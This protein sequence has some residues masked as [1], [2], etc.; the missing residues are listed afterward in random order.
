MLLYLTHSLRSLD[1]IG[2][3]QVRD[4]PAHSGGEQRGQ[5]RR[6]KSQPS[7]A[8]FNRRRERR[9][10]RQHED[11]DERRYDECSHADQGRH[12][13]AALRL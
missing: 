3:Y 13:D 2:K 5:Q 4:Q 7:L 9:R 10:A 6:G 11:T 8:S 12:K 1:Q